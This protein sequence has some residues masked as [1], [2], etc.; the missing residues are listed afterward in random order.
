MVLDYFNLK[1]KKKEII[2]FLFKWDLLFLETIKCSDRG[3]TL[4]KLM[5][6]RRVIK[7]G[8][9]IKAFNGIDHFREFFWLLGFLNKGITTGLLLL[10]SCSSLFSAAGQDSHSGTLICFC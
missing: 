7:F 3:P 8:N 2:P 4:Y 9:L 6:H 5:Q 1:K 10:F